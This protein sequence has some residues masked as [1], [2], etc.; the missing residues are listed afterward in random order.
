M[1]FFDRN[2]IFCMVPIAACIIY[3]NWWA[4]GMSG[5]L[6]AYQYYKAIIQNSFV[7]DQLITFPMWGYGWLMLLTE[8][9]LGLLSIQMTMALGVLY[10]FI[11][12]L[13]QE[14]LF[15]LSL[16]RA[17]KICMVFGIP[18]YAF[19][20]LRWPYSIAAS[21][22]LVSFALLYKAVMHTERS[23][24]H[25]IS[26]AVCFGVL[27]HFRSDYWLMPIG[28]AFLIVIFLKTKRAAFQIG[29]WF[30]SIYMCLIPWTLYTRKACG[31]Y[32]LTSTNSGH[33]LFIGLGNNP[34]NRW[35]IEGQDGDPLM[36]RLVDEHFNKTK[37]STL[38]YQADQFLKATF[39]SYV[40]AYPLEYVKKSLCV[41]YQ[42][43]TGGFYA[44]EF[45]I[46]EHGNTPLLEHTRLRYIL[47]H[48]L[49]HPS[50]IVTHPLDSVR[51]VLTVLSSAMGIIMLFI[52]YLLMPVT[53]WFIVMRKQSLCMFLMFAALFYQ[54]LIN[55][56]CFHMSG[57]MGN[58]YMLYLLQALYG[59]S[60]VY[61]YLENAY[62]RMYQFLKQRWTMV[63]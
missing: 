3:L 45:L 43:I 11:Q 46:D 27:L 30:I 48:M 54:T 58:L 23:W 37:A 20:A 47:V 50:V 29:V 36:H 49:K 15:S 22:F 59:I 60:L 44:G 12:F 40:R 1:H 53:A 26:S 63:F 61:G 51:I 4:Q 28:F 39:F 55:C 57:Y 24:L 62:K 41:F 38:D 34:H 25:L 52:A 16:M 9:K 2:Y 7:A 14:K 35:G 32:L 33:V 6:S 56:L 18:W 5:L 31:H 21:L 8:S 10:W 42:V 19:H 17:L 13:E